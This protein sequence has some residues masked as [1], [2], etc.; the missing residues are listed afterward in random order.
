MIY[1]VAIHKVRSIDSLE[2]LLKKRNLGILCWASVKSSTGLPAGY[3]AKAA[4]R[5]T[6]FNSFCKNAEHA[7]PAFF[8]LIR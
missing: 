6:L 2:R 7:S 4:A 1:S 5:C 8:K 3:R